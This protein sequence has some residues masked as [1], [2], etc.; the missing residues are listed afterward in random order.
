MNILCHPASKQKGLINNG[1]VIHYD[2]YGI[3]NNDICLKHI[4]KLTQ[5]ESIS[6]EVVDMAFYT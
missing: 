6:R 4:Y 1:T 2:D 5:A 3:N